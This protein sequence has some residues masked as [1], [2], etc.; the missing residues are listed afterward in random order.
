VESGIQLSGL[1]GTWFSG[2]ARPPEGDLIDNISP[3]DRCGAIGDSAIVDAFGMGAMAFHCAPA[4]AEALGQFLDTPSEVLSRNLLPVIHPGISA[5]G[6]R[7]GLTAR[8]IVDSNQSLSI[9]LGIL[10]RMGTRGRIGGGIYSPPVELFE[11]A[12]QGLGVTEEQ[13]T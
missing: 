6:I 11:N 9:S 1:P 7:C 3:E 10:D 8:R 12:C 13:E 2:P 4:Q 5:D